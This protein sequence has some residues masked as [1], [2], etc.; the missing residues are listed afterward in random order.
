MRSRLNMISATM[1]ALLVLTLAGASPALAH[2]GRLDAN[3][4]HNCSEK[5]K[6]KGLCT[7]YHYHRG[8]SSGSQE[9]TGSTG[10]KS[11]GGTSSGVKSDTGKSAS[12]KSP[13]GST[14]GGGS[15]KSGKSPTIRESSVELYIDGQQVKLDP[16]PLLVDGSNY[17][18][19]RAVAEL[20]NAG[21]SWESDT[22]T[23]T[24]RKDGTSVVLQVGSTYATIRG[25]K[26]EI[27]ASPILVDNRVYVPVRVISEALGYTVSYKS[28]TDSIHIR[29][30]TS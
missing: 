19:L 18:P 27:P 6:A 1:A 26:K 7:G 15:G 16:K 23:A 30:R 28:E 14:G 22:Q 25:E 20:L 10:G 29:T 5:S 4:G 11:S 12:G 3:G 13:G 21:V 24:I 2:P 8:G 9:T 17:L